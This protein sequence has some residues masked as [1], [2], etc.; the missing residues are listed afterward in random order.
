MHNLTF[1]LS[2]KEIQIISS[3]KFIATFSSAEE[4]DLN[5]DSKPPGVSLDVSFS[6]KRPGKR[7]SIECFI[8]AGGG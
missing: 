6:E 1:S 8:R 7:F 5:F 4:V 2:F 3:E